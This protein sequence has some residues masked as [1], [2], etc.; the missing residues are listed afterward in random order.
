MI[1]LEAISTHLDKRGASVYA[2]NM[3]GNDNSVNIGEA[4]R[5]YHHGGLRDAALAEGLRLLE[6]SSVEELSLRAIA[7]NIGVS[8][9]ALYR[10]YPDK[11][12]LLSAI[13]AEGLARLGVAQT[14][15]MRD[16]SDG[17]EGFAAAGRAYVRFALAHPAVFRLVMSSQ[18]MAMPP[19]GETTAMQLLQ[20]SVAA[21]N[22]DKSEASH[23]ISVL[24]AWSMVHGLAML[25]LD[26]RVPADDPVIDATLS[27]DY[28]RQGFG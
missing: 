20:S 13:A 17:L 8:A 4:E 16:A 3:A 14:A 28:V 1:A 11:K 5:P 10:H 26:K 24:R 15:A 6:T 9:T 21:L 23:A 19:S 22:P 2:I 27:A 7:R 12:A 18:D 25:M